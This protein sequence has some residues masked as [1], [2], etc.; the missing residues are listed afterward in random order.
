[1]KVSKKLK[2][3]IETKIS[4]LDYLKSRYKSLIINIDKKL[5]LCE[6]KMVNDL[7]S[8]KMK[9][10]Q[11]WDN[12]KE[13]FILTKEQFFATEISAQNVSKNKKFS[14]LYFFFIGNEYIVYNAK[15][16]GFIFDLS[17]K[18]IVS[19]RELSM[20]Y[21]DAGRFVELK[22]EDGTILLLDT[23]KLIYTTNCEQPIQYIILNK[24]IVAYSIKL[25]EY[26][27]FNFSSDNIIDIPGN[28]GVLSLIKKENHCI[29]QFDTG[30]IFI[31][32]SYDIISQDNFYSGE[33]KD[34]LYDEFVVWFDY[35]TKDTRISIGSKNIRLFNNEKDGD[36]TVSTLPLDY[37]V[38]VKI[39]ETS[40]SIVVQHS[41]L[42][43]RIFY[44]M[45]ENRIIK[46]IVKLDL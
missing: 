4:N 11:V 22:A 44:L 43:Y 45:D 13:D 19:I 15:K 18:T 2:K 21:S 34:I 40:D 23:D 10:T 14:W 16:R 12:Q 1:M 3:L 29:L 41:A 36:L 27:L 46:R 33:F 38:F 5:F 39:P 28:K 25:E 24:Y 6:I 7:G 31:K 20:I 32:K 42:P 35:K 37:E 8:E 30:F 17:D 9:Y 26:S